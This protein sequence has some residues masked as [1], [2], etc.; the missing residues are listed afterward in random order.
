MRKY[1]TTLLLIWFREAVMYCFTASSSAS[2]PTDFNMSVV[3]KGELS[4]KT[5]HYKIAS[6]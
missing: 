4:C 2:G 6:V 3:H 1:F 5:L